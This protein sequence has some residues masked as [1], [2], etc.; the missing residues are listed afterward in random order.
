MCCAVLGAVIGSFL[1]VVI[2]R[3]PRGES[4]VR[5]GS[6]CPACGHAIRPRDNVPVISWLLLRA[7]CRDC[8][9]PISARYPLVEAGTAALFAAVGWRFGLTWEL[10]PFLYLTGAGLALA[11]IDLDTKRLPDAVVLPSYV[12]AGV[13]FAAIAVAQGEYS[14]LIRAAIGGAAL[15]TFYFLLAFAYPSGMGFGDVKLAGVLGIYLGWL[16]WGSFVIGAF[17]AFLL[18]GVYSIVLLLTRR[19]TRK[20]GVPFGPWMLGGAAVGIAVGG[21]VWEWYLALMV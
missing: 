16:G 18:G 7:R 8:G 15:F 19:A 13:A 5:P 14:P 11:M 1:N 3:V 21:S 20:T 10:L 12:V 17:S 6:A 4:V 2:W 9:V